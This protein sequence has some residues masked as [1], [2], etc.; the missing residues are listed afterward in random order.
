MV[1]YFLH[2]ACSQVVLFP[3]PPHGAT[4]IDHAL[5]GDKWD[6]GAD[7]EMISVESLTVG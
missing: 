2:C 4:E 1:V 5:A 3:S 7:Q 6:F